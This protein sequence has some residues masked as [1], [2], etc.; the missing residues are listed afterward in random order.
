MAK[1][2]NIRHDAI[3]NSSKGPRINNLCIN[4]LTDKDFALGVDNK[5]LGQV[6]W[7]LMRWKVA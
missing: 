7:V 5:T 4:S 3:L 2:K 1:K 6:N